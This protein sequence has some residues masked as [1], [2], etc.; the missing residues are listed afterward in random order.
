M[1]TLEN[2]ERGSAGQHPS[3]PE[4]VEWGVAMISLARTKQRE[5]VTSLH[6]LPESVTKCKQ[7]NL[8]NRSR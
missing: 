2:R 1:K 8:K 7:L 4:L 6:R 5:L 3:V